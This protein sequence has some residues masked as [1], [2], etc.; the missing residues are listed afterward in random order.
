MGEGFE[1]STRVQ[2]QQILRLRVRVADPKRMKSFTF[3]VACIYCP[4][5][6]IVLSIDS[7]SIGAS[8][9]RNWLN[10]E[11]RPGLKNSVLHGAAAV[12]KNENGVNPPAFKA[13]LDDKPLHLWVWEG[14]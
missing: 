11:V 9:E 4:H 8:S 6:N 7:F 12:G 10:R 13:G 14:P 2:T 3:W 1:V 5:F